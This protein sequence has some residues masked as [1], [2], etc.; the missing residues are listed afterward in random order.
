MKAAISF[1]THHDRAEDVAAAISPD[2]T[3]EMETRVVD[4]AVVTDIERGS[5]GSLRSTADDYLRNLSVAADI[6]D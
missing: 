6:L 1:E 2:N 4:G 3:D 5:T